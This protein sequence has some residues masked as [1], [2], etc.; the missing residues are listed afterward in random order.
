MI[1]GLAGIIGGAIVDRAYRKARDP[2]VWLELSALSVALSVPIHLASLLVGAPHLSLV[3][4]AASQVRYPRLQ[5]GAPACACRL[6]LVL[7]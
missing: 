1:A 6:G 7:L 5:L 4:Q 2:A 3:L